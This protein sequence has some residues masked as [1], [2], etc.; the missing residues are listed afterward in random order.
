M[1]GHPI[2]RKHTAALAAYIEQLSADALT[3]YR[4]SRT[5]R[6]GPSQKYDIAI[7][8]P[9]ASPDFEE[10][11]SPVW[12][13]ATQIVLRTPA[14]FDDD[15]AC[16]LAEEAHDAAADALEAALACDPLREFV[17]SENT[18]SADFAQ[19]PIAGTFTLD[20][21]SAVTRA[22]PFDA[23]AATVQEALIDAWGIPTLTVTG[24][25]ASPF[26]VDYGVNGAVAL[27]T[28]DADFTPEAA[29]VYLAVER[30]GNAG[31]SAQFSITLNAPA[32]GVRDFHLD[33]FRNPT[34]ERQ[35]SKELNSF[36]TL[37]AFNFTAMASDGDA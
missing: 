31:Q 28:A 15:H 25:D 2:I 14:E 26:L 17:N 8:V 4:V 30:A 9:H 23:D 20:N 27:P 37:F 7:H 36:I 3:D 5:M 16:E 33:I 1:T 35:Y 11:D 29:R 22:I 19:P 12:K 32:R 34:I 6:L 10:T 18:A 13:L 21:G 24:H